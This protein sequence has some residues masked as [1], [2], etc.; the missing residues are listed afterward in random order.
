MQ[1]FVPTKSCDSIARILDRQRLGKQRV[2]AVQIART[3]LGL[4]S[5]WRNHPAVKMW[6]G[7]EWFLLNIYLTAMMRRWHYLGYDN[8]RCQEQYEQLR[9]LLPKR[10]DKNPPDWWGDAKLT[11]SHRSN[12]LRKDFTYYKR[13]R[14]KVPN[15]LPYVWPV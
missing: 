10:C 9:K 14:W 15:D 6:E 8:D 4:S 1:T 3:L 2:E 13:Y 7:H 11:Q 12:L 5:G